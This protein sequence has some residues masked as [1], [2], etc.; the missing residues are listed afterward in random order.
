MENYTIV[1][2]GHLN[3]HGYLFGGQLL[4]WVD[5]YAWISASREFPGYTLVTRAMDEVEFRTPIVSGSILRFHTYLSTRG[6]SA[7]TYTVEVYADEPGAVAEK[8]V[9]TNHVVFV[10][11]DQNGRKRRIPQSVGPVDIS[12]SDGD[13]TKQG[14]RER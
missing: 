9:F 6:E 1:R 12:Q 5:E 3:H 10:S 11:V 8:L 13:L 7:L 4:K 2:P 14:E